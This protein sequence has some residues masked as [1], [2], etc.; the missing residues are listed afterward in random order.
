ME[1]S[2]STSLELFVLQNLE[3]MIELLSRVV[4]SSL[5]IISVLLS[6]I[7]T[8]KTKAILLLYIKLITELF[9]LRDICR[10]FFLRIMNSNNPIDRII[11]NSCSSSSTDSLEENDDVDNLLKALVPNAE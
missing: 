7:K 10:S 9:V 11:I 4:D 8:I 1:N 3:R 5:E 6:E 2:S